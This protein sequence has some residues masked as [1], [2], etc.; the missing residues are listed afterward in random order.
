LVTELQARGH[1]V[2][3]LGDRGLAG[4]RVSDRDVLLLARREGRAL[5]TLNRLDFF[6]LHRD[7]PDHAGIL[8]CT[9]DPDFA[10]QAERIDAVLRDELDLRGRLVR[11]NR[12]SR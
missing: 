7:H 2:A 11:I 9:L 3:T 1:D 4:Q 5:A 10:A 8:A 12:P 6:R